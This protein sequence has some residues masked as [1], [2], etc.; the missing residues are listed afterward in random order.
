MSDVNENINTSPQKEC[1]QQEKN[2][3]DAKK[4]G[5]IKKSIMIRNNG[6]IQGKQLN[7]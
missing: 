2:H 3:N 6:N 1:P 5:S 7:F 4:E